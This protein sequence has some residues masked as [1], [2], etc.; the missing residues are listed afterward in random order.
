MKYLIHSSAQNT[1]A[2]SQK[3]NQIIL[4]LA[5]NARVQHIAKYELDDRLMMYFEFNTID[6]AVSSI[7]NAVRS[8]SIKDLSIKY[9]SCSRDKLKAEIGLKNYSKIEVVAE[10]EQK[11]VHKKIDEKIIQ[12]MK[13]YNSTISFTGLIE[14]DT[15]KKPIKPIKGSNWE[16]YPETSWIP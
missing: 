2:G 1:H 11:E 16:N 8:V 15:P 4:R 6:D 7:R 12:G 13:L 10:P 5:R 14:K 9:V 3:I